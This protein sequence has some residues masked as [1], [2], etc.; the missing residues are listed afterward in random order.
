MILYVPVESV[1][2][3]TVKVLEIEPLLFE[4]VEPIPKSTV[5]FIACQDNCTVTPAGK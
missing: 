2:F 3:G 5:P 1:V 4:V